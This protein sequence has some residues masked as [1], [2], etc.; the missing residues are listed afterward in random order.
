VFDLLHPP[1]DEE[2][3]GGVAALVW[4]GAGA[5]AAFVVEV[6]AAAFVVGVDAAA[7]EV[8]DEAGTSEAGTTFLPPA[9]LATGGPGKSYCLLKKFLPKRPLSLSL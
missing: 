1:P 3:L 9:S 2:P 8:E 7:F 4:V 5:A 6:D